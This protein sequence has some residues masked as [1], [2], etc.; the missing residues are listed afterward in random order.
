MKSTFLPVLVALV[1]MGATLPVRAQDDSDSPGLAYATLFLP[2]PAGTAINVR[3]WDNSAEN[4]SVKGSFQD[5]LAQH[6]VR[7][8]DNGTPLLLNFETSVESLAVPSV[9]GP[10]LGEVQG[11]N[12]DSRI[13]MN[14]WSNSKDSLLAGRHSDDD[15]ATT[16]YVLRA[17][18]D[19]QDTG[20]RLWQG[21]AHY[22]AV[23]T[24]ETKTFIAMAPILVGEF[25]K[26]VQ[27]K[28]FRLQ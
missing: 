6:G 25:G 8:A 14:L 22:T 16:R 27:P 23:V 28:P 5:A 24:D 7:L 17:T 2:I 9:G 26:N 10:S 11:R 15:S 18:L 12:Y 13:R 19:N 3:P 1:V 21:E 20:E 4:Q